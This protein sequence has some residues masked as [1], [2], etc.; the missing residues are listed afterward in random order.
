MGTRPKQSFEIVVR[1]DDDGMT[2]S[3]SGELDHDAGGYVEAC[4]DAL[5]AVGPKQVTLDLG[6]VTFLDAG[7]ITPILDLR[8]RLTREHG[9]LRV[10]AAS[11]R[12]LQLLDLCDLTEAVAT[13]PNSV[14]HL[15]SCSITV[16]AASSPEALARITVE[17]DL[18]A[19]SLPA[20]RTQ[21]AFA[22]DEGG[23]VELDLGAVEFASVDAARLLLE[24][25]ATARLALVRASRAVERSIVLARSTNGTPP[26][27]PHAATGLGPA[28]FSVQPL[29]GHSSGP[30]RDVFTWT[31]G[32]RQPSPTAETNP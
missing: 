1:G 5:V 6:G 7:G 9:T 19:T 16:G 26:A 4:L 27:T 28:P 22:L 12:V 15:P 14:F 11:E 25:A 8:A 29:A 31:G 18:D 20:L 13:R 23:A 3:V 32:G 17:G 24:D 21:I 2:V 30:V 10:V